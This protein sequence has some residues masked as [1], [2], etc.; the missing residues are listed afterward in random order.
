MIERDPHYF[1]NEVLDAHLLLEEEVNTLLTLAFQVSVP[2]SLSNNYSKLDLLLDLGIIDDS[3]AESFQLFS[4]IRNQFIHRRDCKLF[5]DL[6]VSLRK[7]LLTSQGKSH[8][9][10]ENDEEL[11]L[12][13]KQLFSSLINDFMSKMNKAIHKGIG[14]KKELNE[15]R[16]SLE[17]LIDYICEKYPEEDRDNL[18][19]RFHPSAKKK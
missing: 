6:P 2:A 1:R 16:L 12:A 18:L 3:F 4:R 11:F 7:Q 5:T 10:L 14:D 15:T 8:T 9:D 13:L 17:R 19:R